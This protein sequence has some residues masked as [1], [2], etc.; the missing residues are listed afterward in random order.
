MSKF[1]VPKKPYT[2]CLV[3]PKSL[4]YAKFEPQLRLNPTS[5]PFKRDEKNMKQFGIMVP[6]LITPL[7]VILDG[8]RRCTIAMRWNLKKVWCWVLDV[9]DENEDELAEI[10]AI[11]NTCRQSMNSIQKTQGGF[12]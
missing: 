9:D 1:S 4:N 12:G 11:L 7:G 6:I 2:A 3:S 5:S 8:H 10:F